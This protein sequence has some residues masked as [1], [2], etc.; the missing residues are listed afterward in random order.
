MVL[1]LRSKHRKDASVQ[2]DYLVYVGEIN[3]WPPS[4]SLRSVQSVLLQWENGDQNSGHLTSSIGDT[5]V[6]FKVGFALPVTLRREKRSNDRYQKNLL[7]FSLFEP[8]KDKVTK[9]QLLGTA[10][11]NL[12]DYGIIEDI[13]SISAPL[14][15]KKSSKNT[16]QPV[17]FLRIQQVDKNSSNSTPMTGLSK[18]VSLDKDRQDSIPGSRNEDNDD[19]SEIAS[20]TDDDDDVSSHSSR[21]FAS[22]AF[23]AANSP[24]GDR[25][26]KVG[27]N[28]VAE[29]TVRIKPE[30]ALPAVVYP[31]T[32]IFNPETEAIKR[33]SGTSHT[34]LSKG[35][36]PDV[37]ER[38]I[39]SIKNEY[40]PP[41]VQSS[42]SFLQF[43]DSGRDTTGNIRTFEQENTSDSL[44]EIVASSVDKTKASTLPLAEEIFGKSGA[45]VGA[46]NAYTD[47][48]SNQ[49]ED[50]VLQQS[51][52]GQVEA[53]INTSLY[54]YMREGKEETEQLEISHDEQLFEEKRQ[55]LGK[56]VASKVYQNAAKKQA[57]LSS[58]TLA[59]SGKVIGTSHTLLSKDSVPDVPERNI[60]SIKNE[61]DPPVVQSSSSFLQFLDSGRDTT[62]NIRTF[63]QEN[64]SDSLHEIVSSSVD[65]TKASTLPLAEEIFGKSGARVGAIN[66]YTDGPSNQIEDN[67]LQQSKSGQVEATINTSLDIDMR[68]GKEETEQLEI[69]H[70]EQLFEEKRQTLG[71]KVASKVYQNAAKKQAS[72][73]STT[74]ASSGK[75]IGG[76]GT[77]LTGSK[78]K[79]VNSVQLSLEPAKASM[80]SQNEKEI[81]NLG[82]VNDAQSNLT[83][84]AVSGR[85]ELVNGS[86]KRDE[87]RSKAEIFEEELRETA[88]LEVSLYSVVAEHGGSINKVHAPARRLSRFYLHAC[89]T[90]YSDKR[91]SAARASVS[92]LVLVSKACGNDVPRLTFWLSNS[93]MLRAIV[94]KTV[95]ELR[96]SDEPCIKSSVGKGKS[97]EEFDDW[98]DPVTFTKALEK[99]EAWIFSRIVESVWWQ[100]LTPHMQ[101]AA[102]KSSR[103]IGS[104]SRKSNGNKHVLRDQEQGNNSI[105]LWK[106]A[107]KDA[108]ERLCPIRAGGHEC[109]CLPVLARLVM[110]QLVSRLD[111]AMFNAILRESAEEMPTDPVSDPIADSKVL[112]V[113]S[114]RSSFGAGAQLKNAIGNWSRW[115]TDL[116][117]IEDN[118]S[119]EGNDTLGD[120]KGVETDTSFKPFRLLNALS[121]LMMLPFE[122]LADAPTRKEVC[123]T[124]SAQLIRRVFINFVPDE[125]CPEPI[126]SSVIESLDSEDAPAAVDES[127]TFFPCNANP[128]VYQP[129][130][131]ASFSSIVGEM[132][133]HE[134]RRSGSSVR[135]KAYASDDELD[136]LESPLTSIL[137][138][139]LLSVQPLTR[140]KINEKGGRN[141]VRYQ[142]L[143]EVWR[144]GE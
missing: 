134:L 53:T 118:D 36:V 16:L 65:K 120:Y 5:S 32:A 128:T 33:P 2:V 135:R 45:R 101:P 87:W 63:E 40:D 38:N 52:S 105:E 136:E 61:Y 54:I 122:M 17:L 13:V 75:V 74:L 103:T 119:H 6:Q 58:T 139:N 90:R 57:S 130:A 73:S 23:E 44:H 126:P 138:D 143:R 91:A 24:H 26:E 41:V 60:T 34:L 62:G 137:S 78:P 12:A 109:G 131:A 92:G 76:Q 97:T 95:G 85:K 27:S 56:K 1:G 121:D 30:P 106:K 96:L 89:K 15:C 133:S 69:S 72:L 86:D 81:N 77:S 132:G 88:A 79:H 104:S 20:F 94:R 115:L 68:E 99:V 123:P 47:G 83:N 64:T 142:L 55:A 108:C 9:G 4:Q 37:P 112:P 14:S 116:F 107:F 129:P 31:L 22:S 111:V 50:N 19:V 21:T 25:S 8:K 141:V 39:T 102:A 10:I 84:T 43:L 29:N 3:P 70:D 35:S 51:K 18:Q 80:Y 59:S 127:L 110:E 140:P 71:K 98:E 144:D 49:I 117:G 48:P 93:I 114:G 67:V 124:F 82:S 28:M 46:I 66:A 100:T 125:F 42:S 7:E 113:P 11:I